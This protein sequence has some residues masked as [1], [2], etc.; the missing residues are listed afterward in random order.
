[1]PRRLLAALVLVA[2]LACHGTRRHAAREAVAPPACQPL[3]DARFEAEV[4]SLRRAIAAL[5]ASARPL[6]DPEGA[7]LLHARVLLDLGRPGEARARAAEVRGHDTEAKALRA[8]AVERLRPRSAGEIDRAADLY[9]RAIAPGEPRAA[10]MLLEAWRLDPPNGPALLEAGRRARDGSRAARL[11]ERGVSELEQEALVPAHAGIAA[12]PICG[13]HWSNYLHVEWLPDGEHFVITCLDGVV[14]AE[15]RGGAPRRVGALDRF[16]EV[17]VARLPRLRYLPR[18]EPGPA[19]HDGIDGDRV[20]LPRGTWSPPLRLPQGTWLSSTARSRDGELVFA[21]ASAQDPFRSDGLVIAI[22]ARAGRELARFPGYEVRERAGGRFVVRRVGGVDVLDRALARK[23]SIPG[24]HGDLS[25]DG[26]RLV[27]TKPGPS[28]EDW[29]PVEPWL[30]DLVSG[31]EIDLRPLLAP[32]QLHPAAASWPR[33]APVVAERCL[34]IG[35]SDG[36]A[37]PLPTLGGRTFGANDDLA[38]HPIEGEGGASYA[39]SP[40]WACLDPRGPVGDVRPSDPSLVCRVG[41]HVL[42]LGECAHLL[43]R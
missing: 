13:G 37:R 28:E 27:F 35:M 5:E 1:M 8:E 19:W 14:V 12:P 21:L 20:K 18:P 17:D 41:P 4:G 32:G 42:P 6:C 16:P 9:R 3:D 24:D 23:Q 40:R 30:R 43:A 11:F 10:E 33:I 26:Q 25:A 7:A 34:T 31:Q 29:H 38:C 22:D 2:P 36:C 39:R 15:L